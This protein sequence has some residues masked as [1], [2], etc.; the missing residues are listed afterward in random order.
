MTL[1]QWRLIAAAAFLVA[2]V[3]SG[4][5]VRREI[6]RFRERQAEAVRAAESRDPWALIGSSALHAYCA[7][8]IDELGIDESQYRLAGVD[9]S[10]TA[11]AQFARL[12]N[13]S[14]DDIP[15]NGFSLTIPI[16]QWNMIWQGAYM[17]PRGK[18]E[19]QTVTDEATALECA[20]AALSASAISVT[21]YSVKAS[22]IA[23]VW[24]VRYTPPDAA[25]PL[26]TVPARLDGSI[27]VLVLYKASPEAPQPFKTRASITITTPCDFAPT[28]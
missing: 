18:A 24:L 8:A 7:D 12:S 10:V 21:D 13:A 17:T 22:Q 15:G 4:V 9:Y 14:P 16:S 2:F 26:H 25:A 28:K 23:G 3:I 6:A 27:R 11:V 20:A 19:L 5:F 1:R